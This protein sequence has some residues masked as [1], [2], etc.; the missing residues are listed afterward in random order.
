M[1][2]TTGTAAFWADRLNMC[3]SPWYPWY[4]VSASLNLDAAYATELGLNS[5][6][7]VWVSS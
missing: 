2:G 6:Y 3:N 5:R 1:N 4:C 7:V